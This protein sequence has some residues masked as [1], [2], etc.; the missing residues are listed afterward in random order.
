MMVRTRR[1]MF[2]V[3]AAVVVGVVHGATTAPRAQGDP[4]S[5]AQLRQLAYI[6]ASNTDGFDHFACGG[7][8]PGHIGNAL[9]ISGD[10]STMAIG[11]PHESSAATGINGDQNDNSL[12][13]SGAVYVYVRSGDTWTQQAYIKASNA[14]QSDTFGL[15]LALSTDGNTLAVAAPWEASAVTGVNGN[16]ND[17]SLAQAGAVYVFTRDGEAWSQHAYL[18]ASNTGRQGVGDDRD[19]DQFGFAIALSGDGNTLAAGAVAEDSSATGING[20]QSDDSA[21]S[22]GAVYVFS[23]MGNSWAQ[24]AYIKGANTGQGDLFGYGVALSSNGASMVVGGYD[25]DGSGRGVN[26]V[27]DNDVFGSGAIYAFDRAGD[28]W[29]QSG[30][31]KGSR[32]QRNDALGY[33]VAISADGNTIAAGAGDESCLNGG[34]NPSGCDVDTF[35]PELGAGSSGAA[36][37]WVRSGDVWTEQAFI[38]ASNPEL[39]DWFAVRLALSGDGSRLVVGAPMEDSDARGFN[40]RQNDNSA[41]DSGAAFI[42]S[43]T[44]STW[45]QDTYVKAS[46]A[47]SFD[48]FGSSV[49]VSGDGRTIAVG[50]RMESGAATN[51]NGDQDNNDAGQSGAV[52]VFVQ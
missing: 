20:D 19:G 3:G 26:P 4:A 15:S 21:T 22:S 16:Q 48:E 36:Y 41:L 2:L 30:Y 47:D 28:T 43:R 11:A 44:G 35:P 31:L 10:G 38:K 39:A 42:Y 17:D 29:R 25:E 50:A 9:A 52:Y 51:F 14:G 13:N 33:T 8:L 46:N 24:Q 40:G 27:D 32:S 45:S 12:Y 49:A 1:A 18:K 37:V 34:V 6:K 5:A 7:S 23:R